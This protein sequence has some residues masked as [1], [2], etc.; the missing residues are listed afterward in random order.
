MDLAA[1]SLTALLHSAPATMSLPL[2]LEVS[3]ARS[4]SPICMANSPLALVS[5]S[6]IIVVSSPKSLAPMGVLSSTVVSPVVAR[7]VH[8]VSRKARNVTQFVLLDDTNLGAGSVP[9]SS[10]SE[11]AGSTMPPPVP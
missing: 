11:A 7:K 9:A 6:P 10:T 4:V 8:K 1:S 5:H 2:I 3:V